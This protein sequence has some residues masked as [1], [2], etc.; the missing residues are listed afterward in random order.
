[1]IVIKFYKL[2]KTLNITTLN[3]SFQALFSYCCNLLKPIKHIIN[4]KCILHF[5]LLSN[6]NGR[7]KFSFLGLYNKTTNL[8]QL[9]CAIIMF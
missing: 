7:E 5:K 3:P 2:L 1:M 8:N 9:N 6:T 4:L